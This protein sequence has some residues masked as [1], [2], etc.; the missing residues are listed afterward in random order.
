[1]A[2]EGGE[3]AGVGVAI[4]KASHLLLAL[5]HEVGEEATVGGAHEVGKEAGMGGGGQQI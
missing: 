4:G 5:D 3:E 1:M 2:E